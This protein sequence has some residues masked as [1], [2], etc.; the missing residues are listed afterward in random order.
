VVTP[1][2]PTGWATRI[3]ARL[4]T[5]AVRRWP[6]RSRTGLSAEW[7]AEL[8]ELAHEPD[9]GPARR[10]YHQLRFAASLAVARPHGAP[11]SAYAGRGERLTLSA[12]GLFAA[13]TFA[14]AAPLFLVIALLARQRPPFLGPPQWIVAFAGG[15]VFAAALAVV[16]GQRLLIRQGGRRAGPV[17]G[18]LAPA[19]PLWAGTVVAASIARTLTLAEPAR[20]GPLWPALAAAGVTATIAAVTVVLLLHRARLW[21]AAAT[22]LLAAPLAVAA[23][24]PATGGHPAAEPALV[25]MAGTVLSAGFAFRVALPLPAPVPLPGPAVGPS[26]AD[27]DRVRWPGLAVTAAGL[28]AWLTTVTRHT[29]LLHSSGWAGWTN[30]D[31]PMRT[32]ELRYG[33]LLCAVLGFLLAAAHRGAPL[34]PGLAW[35]GALT[36][37]DLAAVAARASG[38]RW[39]VWLAGAAVL[40]G[41]LAWSATARHPTAAPATIRG[42]SLTEPVA[43]L[44]AYCAMGAFTHRMSGAGLTMPWDVLAVAV[45][46]P[47]LLAVLAGLAM[48]DRRR[49]AGRWLPAALG[50]AV[51]A[52]GVVLYQPWTPV[53]AVVVPLGLAGPLVLFTIAMLRPGRAGPPPPH[54]WRRR[55]G[56]IPV[57]VA[58]PILSIMIAVANAWAS[59]IVEVAALRPLGFSISRHGIAYLPG[60]LLLGLLFA[61]LAASRSAASRG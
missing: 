29:P 55:L 52:G 1:D 47:T 8:H 49:R 38:P 50:L 43:V 34:L 33:A 20:G 48:T 7:S 56:W 39:V 17:G 36:V 30:D 24:L 57:A 16:L 14:V 60:E 59:A 5:V 13:P 41:F 32:Q 4:L 12:L 6:D 27:G 58:A 2:G 61:I 28:A 3:A 53:V 25:A 51:L 19:V 54:R 18:A 44:A 22:A 35:A 26:T 31:M 46:V 21:A 10:A 45:A 9:V 23:T 42:R 15:A 40:T 37:L 11:A